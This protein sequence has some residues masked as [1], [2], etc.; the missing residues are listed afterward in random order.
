MGLARYLWVKNRVN[1]SR[2]SGLQY[3]IFRPWR[4]YDATIFLKSM[5]PMAESKAASLRNKGAAIVFDANVNHYDVQGFSHYQDMLPTREQQ[6]AAISM[7]IQ[8]DAVIAD[9]PYLQEKVA[10]LN[11]RVSWIP[12]CVEMSQVPD[13][14]RWR[15]NGGKLPLLWCGQALKLFELLAIEDVLEEFSAHVELILVTNQATDSPRW[16]KET[17]RAF[18]RLLGRVQHCFVPFMSIKQLFTIYRSGGVVISPRFLD[19]TYNLGHTEWKITLGMACGRLA[20]CDGV[21]S[22][23]VVAQR[24]H[25]SGVRVCMTKDD[26]REHLDEILR[27][28]IDL[29]AEGE[30]ARAVVEKYY[31]AGVVADQHAGFVKN[32]L[33]NRVERTV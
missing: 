25:S 14:E 27:S 30:H 28:R 18:Q 33:K 4:K 7:T 23:K 22:Y 3:E 2:N 32:L 5:G 26:W 13:Y 15:Y 12:D 1:G 19:N 10:P 29:A 8:S 6:D 16:T 17:H 20:L 21:P 11:P 24:A 9:S 31:S